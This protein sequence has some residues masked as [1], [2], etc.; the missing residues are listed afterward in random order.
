MSHRFFYDTRMSQSF[1]VYRF[2]P[3]GHKHTPS[4]LLLL[5]NPTFAF[6]LP[7]LWFLLVTMTKTTSADS[8]A[9]VIRRHP[10]KTSIALF[11]NIHVH[12]EQGSCSSLNLQGCTESLLGDPLRAMISLYTLMEALA[13][14]WCWD[15]V[16]RPY[17]GTCR[18]WS[19]HT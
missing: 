7:C 5:L 2:T 6:P 16:K 19:F 14:D 17:C 13:L 9:A 12:I 8:I 4:F 18:S 1:L 3:G 15:E 10:P 11:V